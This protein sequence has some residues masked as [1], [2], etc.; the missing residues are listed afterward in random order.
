M[1]VCDI[2]AFFVCDG[3]EWKGDDR[4]EHFVVPAMRRSVREQG[5]NVATTKKNEVFIF[6]N[7]VM[8]QICFIHFWVHV[9]CNLKC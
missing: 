9:Y 4:P 3:P 8:F 7:H 2:V 1:C 6:E 5:S